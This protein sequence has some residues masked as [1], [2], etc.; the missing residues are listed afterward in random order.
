MATYRDQLVKSLL[1]WPGLFLNQDDVLD[2]LF[3]CTG[4]GYKWEN[5]QLVEEFDS[6]YPE[7]SAIQAERADPWK[8]R[9]DTR[10]YREGCTK[11]NGC[12]F[13]TASGHV[14]KK[15]HNLSENYDA[16]CN[17]PDDIQPD[18]IEAAKV[19]LKYARSNRVRITSKERAI[20]SRVGQRIKEIERLR[21]PATKRTRKATHGQDTVLA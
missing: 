17:L 4:N 12:Y 10:E 7:D 13:M 14:G 11:Y 19:A 5:G 9:L 1:E 21:K 18:W 3:F 16:I 20:L 15:M 2:H 6:S 8:T